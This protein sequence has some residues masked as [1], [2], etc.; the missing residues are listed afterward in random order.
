MYGQSHRRRREPPFTRIASIE[1]INDEHST[2]R[3]YCLVIPTEEY[4]YSGGHAVRLFV[5]K[6]LTIISDDIPTARHRRCLWVRTWFAKKT[7]IREFPNP[8]IAALPTEAIGQ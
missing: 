1:H 6:K 7:G 8:V 5:P 2:S 3:A 4:G